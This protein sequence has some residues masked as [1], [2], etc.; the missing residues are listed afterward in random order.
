MINKWPR[1]RTENASKRLFGELTRFKSRLKK[2]SDLFLG[3]PCNIGADYKPLFDVFEFYTHLNNIGD[4]FV[5]SKYRLNSR[6]FER[7][8]LQFFA[9]LYKIR[10]YWGYVT[11]GGTEGNMYGLFVGRELYPDG[12]LYFSEESHYSI[13]K[14]ARV[15]RMKHVMIRSLETGQID[16]QD[17]EEMIKVNRKDP[18]IVNLNIGTTMKGAIDNLETILEIIEKNGISNY[19]IHCDAALF[20]MM[21]PFMESAPEI[22]FAKH[23]DSI[24]I[25]GHKFIGSPI[26][27]GVVLTRKGFVRRIERKIEYIGTLDTTITGSRNGHSPL[28]LWYA[29]MTKGY[30]G[31]KKEVHSCVQ[32]AKY[33][34]NELRKMNYPGKL[35]EFSNIVYFKKPPD[36]LISKW[37]LPTQGDWAHI[38]VMQ[39]VT[40]PK[41]KSFVENLKNY[42]EKT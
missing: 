10:D 11:T 28:I 38:V 39:H 3:Y 25:S 23:I 7:H 42:E 2:H 5:E 18:I 19:Y 41:I 17:F 31:F 20:G 21:T 29:I 9:D 34:F 32:N 16:Y 15:L 14:I 33:L 40:K 36:P 12:I 35:N 24:A 26:P 1:A 37:Q 22:S 4:P 27:C 8:V 6:E 30:N 13:S